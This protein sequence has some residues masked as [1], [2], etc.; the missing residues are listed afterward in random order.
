MERQKPIGIFDS[1]VGGLS[2]GHAIRTALPEED[3][4]YFADLGFSPYGV[5]ATPIIR[6]RSEYI[7]NFLIN[8]G[9]KAVVVAC[10]TATVN[11][12]SDLRSKFSIPIFGVEPGIKPAALQSK[13]GVIGVLATQQTLESD[14]FQQLK[15]T[16][17]KMVT[18]ETMACPEFVSLVENL[19]HNGDKATDVAEHYIRPLLSAGSDQ[20]ILGC[21]HFSFLIS[22]I[23]K[24]VGGEATI[25]DTA[26]PVAMEVSRRL[27]ALN[28]ENLNS[29]QGKAAFWTSG[30]VANVIGPMSELWGSGINVSEISP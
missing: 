5:K 10:N 12:I 8:Q 26:T 19:N 15:T 24:V 17:S 16:Y 27:H 6:E 22:A 1:G 4:M 13:T 11:T 28:L 18:I 25:I 3:L 2:I 29:T 30:N 7:V 9:C 20:I 23:N 14:S 21:T